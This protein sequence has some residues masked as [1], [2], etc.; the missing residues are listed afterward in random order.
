MK[1]T[2]VGRWAFGVGRS[3]FGVRA[4]GFGFILHPSAFILRIP[5]PVLEPAD[6]LG[7]AG[8]AAAQDHL[9]DG[10]QPALIGKGNRLDGELGEGG[11]EAR[12]AEAGVPEGADAAG[13]EQLAAGALR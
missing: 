2:G 11:D 6:E 12:V 4:R 7:V 8:A 13:A 10:T 5:D 1:G 9:V 3:A